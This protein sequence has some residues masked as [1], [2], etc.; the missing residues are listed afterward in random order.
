MYSNKPVYVT[1]CLSLFYLFP[2][3]T[4]Y[5]YV[6]VVCN[7]THV[8]LT[9]FV[10]LHVVMSNTYCVVLLLC[11]SSSCLSFVVSFCGLSIVDC[12]FGVL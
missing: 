7:G 4:T 3:E 10:Y 6:P 11:F 5:N 1:F 12:L 9:L 2:A 8:L